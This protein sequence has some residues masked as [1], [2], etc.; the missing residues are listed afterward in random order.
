MDAF[1]TSA[2]RA[3][4]QGYQ[5]LSQGQPRAASKAFHQALQEQP[6][7]P[8]GWLGLAAF[9]LSTGSYTGVKRACQHVMT[10]QPAGGSEGTLATILLQIIDRRYDQ[11]LQQLQNYLVYEN[12]NA[13]ALALLGYLLQTMGDTTASEQAYTRAEQ[14][15]GGRFANSFQAVTPPASSPDT[16]VAVAPPAQNPP[17]QQ[18]IRLAPVTRTSWLRQRIVT[19]TLMFIL[20]AIYAATALQSQ[21]TDISSE[22]LI[23]WGGQINIAVTQGE[24]WRLL[25]AVFLHANLV[26]VIMNTI[27]L[28]FI[29]MA[30]ELFYGKWRY[31]VIFVLAGLVGNIFTFFLMPPMSLSIGASGGVFGIFGALG[32]FYLINRR[33]LGRAFPRLVR[34]WLFFL[35]INL[36]FGLAIPNIN[37]IAHFGGLASGFVLGLVLA[38]KLRPRLQSA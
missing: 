24:Y 25:T 2:Q 38:R 34:E 22:V 36:I 4:E 16:E 26:H 13:Y 3:I 31:L 5:A 21:N 10:L 37:N 12:N 8:A 1:Q 29:G 30:I 28:Y 18:A 6:D 14:I 17:P 27:S 20:L 23:L 35:S 15:S 19:F 32:A 33:A 9:S 7:N 11:A